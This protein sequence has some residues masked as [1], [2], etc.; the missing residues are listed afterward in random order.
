MNF[1]LFFIFLTIKCTWLLA[2]YTPDQ[3][4]SE[5]MEGNKRFASGKS[6]HKK[7][8]QEA[9]LDRS[10]TQAPF[11]IILGCS[12]AR[13]PTEMIFD[14]DLGELFIVRVAG[15][16]V[17]ETERASIEFAVSKLH[18]PLIVVLGHQE[19]GAIQTVL[20]DPENKAGLGTI[21]SLIASAIAKCPAQKKED[22]LLSAIKCN[23]RKSVETLESSPKL[24]PYLIEKK[25]KIVGGYYDFKTGMVTLIPP[26]K[27]SS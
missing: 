2:D 9:R 18:V 4:L 14:R 17:G 15:N 5:L 12:D 23:V 27:K 20:N 13:A 10:R 11:A 8:E 16:V 1:F 25:V 26:M 22:S 6:T 3:A 24:S 19:C 7:W 21:H